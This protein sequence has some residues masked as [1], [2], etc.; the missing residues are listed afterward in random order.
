LV[1]CKFGDRRLCQ[2]E[3]LARVKAD[4]DV[5][6]VE[7]V[8]FRKTIGDQLSDLLHDQRLGGISLEKPGNR[9]GH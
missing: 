4:L 2:E 3:R 9:V 5:H 7:H 6:V 1:S 8:P